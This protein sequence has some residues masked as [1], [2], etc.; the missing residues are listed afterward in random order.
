MHIKSRIGIIIFV[1][2]FA[3]ILW[4]YYN[5]NKEHL[6]K[7]REN[8]DLLVTRIISYE[9]TYFQRVESLSHLLLDTSLIR[10]NCI[11]NILRNDNYN[12]FIDLKKRK[13]YL[14]YNLSV[15]FNMDNALDIKEYNFINYFLK[16]NFIIDSIPIANT[17]C[18]NFPPDGKIF[19]FDKNNRFIF[20]NKTIT[21]SL[22]NVFD[23]FIQKNKNE[24]SNIGIYKQTIFRI[25]IN[26]N[27]SISINTICDNCNNEV[28]FTIKKN[29]E[30]IKDF[31]KHINY[32]NIKEYD[33]L[34][35]VIKRCFIPSVRNTA[36]SN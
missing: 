35:Y 34:Y 4:K 19:V 1:F 27:D 21:N 13:Y 32:E 8:T 26:S 28:G 31:Y 18:D 7:I 29:K 22:R 20:P 12:L 30:L 11:L 33:S 5:Y 36:H 2:L 24:L 17:I 10:Q 25:T 23:N 6:T 9:D 15:K 16:K 14:L 3:I